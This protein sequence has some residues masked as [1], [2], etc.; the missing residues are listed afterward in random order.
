M[1]KYYP[2]LCLFVCVFVAFFCRSSPLRTSPRK[3][4]PVVKQEPMS[5]AGR[6]LGKGPQSDSEAAT[7]KGASAS[8][9]RRREQLVAEAAKL[10]LPGED[11]DDCQQ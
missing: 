8:E 10:P 6:R 5:P 2:P 4:Q 3:R 7:D 9:I 11:N 1:R